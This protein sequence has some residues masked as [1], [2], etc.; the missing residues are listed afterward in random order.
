MAI[1]TIDGETYA[2]ERAICDNAAEYARKTM[3]SRGRLR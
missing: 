1:E 2:R 3:A